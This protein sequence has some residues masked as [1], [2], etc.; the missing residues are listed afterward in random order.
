M[1]GQ[2]IYKIIN[3]VNG[4]FYVGSTTNTRERFR[5]HRKR[6]RNNK[7]HASHLQAAWNKYGENAFVFHVIQIVPDGESLQA[8]EDVWLAEHVGKSHCYNKSRYSNAPMRGI[9]KEQHPNFGR[10]KTEE[11]WQ[12]I[13]ESL[14]A[15]YAENPLSHPRLGKHHT[16][17]TKERIR[18]IKL[19]NPTRAWLGKERSAETKA[20][21]SAAQKGVAKAPRV[22]TEEGLARAQENMRQNAREQKPMD[23]SA[24]L[25]KFPD[26]VKS[27]YDFSQAI[28]TSALVRIEN[29]I[30]PVHGAF[31]QYAAQFR[32]GRG[33]PSC[34]QD[35]RSATRSAQMKQSWAN[36]EE[37]EK[38]MQAR[39]KALDTP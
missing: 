8:A 25:A 28:Y 37:R 33:C 27:K 31:S 10:S 32:K 9:P 24:V 12:V 30:C 29:C 22:Y 36:P 35:Q 11:E 21:I 1:K 26:E 5:T 38:M 17:E 14:K 4:K 3:T 6:L 23:F 7:H 16:G 2:V 15:F 18:Q 20:K 13:S 34:G 39:Q 19:A